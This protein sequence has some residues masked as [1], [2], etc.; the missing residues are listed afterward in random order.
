MSTDRLANRHFLVVDDEEF[1]RSLVVRFLKQ[2]GAAGVVE[3]GDG[4]QAIEAIGES[5][6]AFDAVITDI[7]MRAMNGLELL[8]AIRCGARGLKRNMPVLVLTAHAEAVH[9]AEALALDADAFVVKPVG[10]EP[11]I[12]RVLRVLERTVPI[13]PVASYGPTPANA[14]L[15]SPA[16]KEM[17]QG[18]VREIALGLVKENSILTQDIHIGNPE[19]LLVAAPVILTKAMLDRLKDLSQLHDGSQLSVVEPRFVPATLLV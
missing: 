1:I 17:A 4:L 10:R 7:N 5:D 6:M 15:S 14:S 13:R 11:L 2:A 19:M 12:D 8:R 9:V 18:Q 3:A 16:S